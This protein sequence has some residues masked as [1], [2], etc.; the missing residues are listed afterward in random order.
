MRDGGYSVGF[1]ASAVRNLMRIVDLQPAF[2]YLVGIASIAFT[3][4]GKRLGDIVAGTLVVRE[5][6]I[7]QPLRPRAPSTAGTVAP[8]TARLTDAE[9]QLLER[10]AQR[11]NSRTRCRRY[12]RSRRQHPTPARAEQQLL[13][14]RV[15][16]TRRR[17]LRD[18]RPHR[19]R[20][21]RP[22]QR[23]IRRAIWIRC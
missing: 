2:S 4:S 5:A 15:Q 16:R 6:L 14:P 9:F 8:A 7:N 23:R 22:V 12:R 13:A 20:A 10:W 21:P 18:Q 1:A 3:K 19:P 11:R 17:S